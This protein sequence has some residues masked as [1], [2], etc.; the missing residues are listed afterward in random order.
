MVAETDIQLGKRAHRKKAGSDD[1]VIYCTVCEEEIS[2]ETKTVEKLAHTGVKRVSLRGVG[3]LSQIPGATE[4]RFENNNA[5]FLYRGDQ[6]ELIRALS[7]TS[8]EDITIADPDFEEI[9]LHYYSR[10]GK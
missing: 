1:E 4:L 7:G 9:F 2:R 3:A 5:S 6:T 10:E 8:F